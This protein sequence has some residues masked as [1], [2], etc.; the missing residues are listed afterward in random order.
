MNNLNNSKLSARETLARYAIYSLIGLIFGLLASSVLGLILFNG[1][2]DLLQKVMNNLSDYPQYMPRILAFNA[3]FLICGLLLPTL[4]FFKKYGER[5]PFQLSKKNKV[6]VE[7]LVFLSIMLMFAILPL[8]SIIADWNNNIILPNSWESFRIAALEKE[9]AYNEMFSYLGSNHNTFFNT[10]LLTLFM[11]VVPAIAEEIVFRGIIQNS[12]IKL[13]KNPHLA[14]WS[15]GVIF[16]LI[17]FSFFGFFPRVVMGAFFGYLYFY[18]G[19][20][21]IPVIAHFINNFIIVMAFSFLPDE[22]QTLDHPSIGYIIVSTMIFGGLAY[23][24]IR[25]CLQSVEKPELEENI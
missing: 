5:I 21:Y 3:F 19:K 25:T 16:S 9:Q 18:S 12:L 7:F 17:H 11:A 22:A 20:F 24:F 4:L 2:N 23:V 10:I 6:P 8:I 14:I 13:F 1:S 15:A